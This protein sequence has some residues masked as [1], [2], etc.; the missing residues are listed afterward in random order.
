MTI[1][2]LMGELHKLKR[3]DKLRAIQVLARFSG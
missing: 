1:E 3:V 2:E